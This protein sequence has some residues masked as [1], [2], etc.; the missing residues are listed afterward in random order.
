MRVLRTFTQFIPSHYLNILCVQ[1]VH[2]LTLNS[3]VDS[4]GVQIRRFPTIEEVI[5]ILTTWS[6]YIL[7]LLSIVA[8]SFVV[9][10]LCEI[11]LET[12]TATCKWIVSPAPSH[13]LLVCLLRNLQLIILVKEIIN[14]SLLMALRLI[15]WNPPVMVVGMVC[16]VLIT[17]LAVIV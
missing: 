12:L 9:V 5:V 11:H 1:V 15:W 14:V 3:F 8:S 7:I 13:L 10:D 4:G 16:G 6:L 17:S 2:S